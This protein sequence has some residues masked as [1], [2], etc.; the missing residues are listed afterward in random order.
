MIIYSTV[1]KW[2]LLFLEKQN[3]IHYEHSSGKPFVIT[4]DHAKKKNEK[5]RENERFTFTDHS[6][7]FPQILK[8][9]VHKIAHQ[10]LGY[11]KLFARWDRRLLT[12]EYIMKR[13][14]SSLDFLT[15]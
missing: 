4:H 9:I 3:I 10:K 5:V 14:G 7:Q 13:M 12:D 15:R 11:H 6:E 2:F 1:K 8:T